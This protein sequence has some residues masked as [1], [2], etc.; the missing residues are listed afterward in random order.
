MS[1]AQ[2]EWRFC[3][4]GSGLSHIVE[5]VHGGVPVWFCYDGSGPAYTTPL[6]SVDKDTPLT[7]LWCAAWW[8]P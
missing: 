5:L 4:V 8:R 2:K 3:D 7:C 6:R 1:M